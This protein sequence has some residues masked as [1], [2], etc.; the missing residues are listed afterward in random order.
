MSIVQKQRELKKKLME[1]L[2][3]LQTSVQ[4]Q[5]DFSNNI[6]HNFLKTH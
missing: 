1:L 2:P 6:L 4:G 3:S 5:K